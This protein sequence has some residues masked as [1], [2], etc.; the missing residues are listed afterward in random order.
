MTDTPGNTGH[1]GAQLTAEFDEALRTPSMTPSRPPES[2][3]RFD[4]ASVASLR[5]HQLLNGCVSRVRG[6]DKA[7]TIARREVA[8]GKVPFTRSPS[9]DSNRSGGVSS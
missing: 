2:W 4:F 3:N 6:G 8:A 9:E 7:T 1:D 5:S